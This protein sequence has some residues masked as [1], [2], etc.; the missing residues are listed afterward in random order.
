MVLK[1]LLFEVHIK[2]GCQNTL[3]PKFQDS[4]SF[5]FLYSP[6]CV[7]PVLKPHC[8]FSHETAHIIF[9]F[10]ELIVMYLWDFPYIFN[11][12]FVMSDHRLKLGMFCLYEGY[13]GGVEQVLSNSVY[14]RSIV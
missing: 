9:A 12:D 5:L 7:G 1:V 4:S 13:L 3:N 11:L 8:W 10:I 2:S 14:Q 6:V